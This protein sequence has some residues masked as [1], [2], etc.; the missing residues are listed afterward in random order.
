VP[1]EAARRSIEAFQ[2]ILDDLLAATNASRTTLRLDWPEWGLHVDDVAAEARRPG[3]AS[4][5]GQTSIDQ[6]RAETVRWLE[7]E[8]HPLVQDDCSTA[9]H[10]PP[11]E[12][13]ELYGV[14]AQMLGPV[15][16]DGHLVG[17]VSVH[18]NGSTRRWTDEDFVA[19][20]SATAEID[21]AL[22]HG[23]S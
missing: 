16:R 5:A 18:E 6:R 11:R 22:S 1:A 14:R 3:V 20:T 2:R 23:R 9:E 13:V 8:L 21:R 10:A 12:L 19:L 4:L 17:W 15:V 7:R